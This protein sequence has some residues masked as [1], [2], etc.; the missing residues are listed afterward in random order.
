MKHLYLYLVGLI[1]AMMVCSCGNNINNEN[2]RD[3]ESESIENSEQSDDYQRYKDAYIDGYSEEYLIDTLVFEN[4]IFKLKH[5][6]LFDSSIVVPKESSWSS[7]KKEEFITHQYAL[8]IEISRGNDIL[9]DTIVK[10]SD[11]K[12]VLSEELTKYGVIKKPNLRYMDGTIDICV[13]I[14]IPLTDVGKSAC[15][16]IDNNGG[17]R[18]H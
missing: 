6:C 3:N 15:L 7:I 16:Q 1:T 13:S 9:L 5:Y 17:I 4:Y 14:S 12:P 10:K 18:I 8:D 11:F 2:N